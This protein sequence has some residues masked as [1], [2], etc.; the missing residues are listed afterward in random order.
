MIRF[1]ELQQKTKEINNIFDDLKKAINDEYI[2]FLNYSIAVGNCKHPLVKQEFMQHASEE[3]EHAL[4]FFDILNDLGGKHMPHIDSITFKND[5]PFV[6][7]VGDNIN[8]VEENIKAEQCAVISYT[9]LLNAYEWEP[10]HAQIIQKIINDEEMHIQD[11]E[12][13]LPE[14]KQEKEMKELSKDDDDDD[15]EAQTAMLH[16]PSPMGLGIGLRMGPNARF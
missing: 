11:L 12:G 7:P 13:I 16:A 4:M 5:C 14:L 3:H 2:S 1:K 15:V 6:M 10:E 8:K 9:K